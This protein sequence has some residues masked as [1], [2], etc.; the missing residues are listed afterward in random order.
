RNVD[1]VS[2]L[3][4]AGT[5]R[6]TLFANGD[7]SARTVLY[8]EPA[9]ELPAGERALMLLWGGRTAAPQRFRAPSL[10]RLDGPAQRAAVTAA[11]ERLRQEGSDPLLLYCTGHGSQSRDR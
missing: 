9:R 5:P 2:H 7:T 11:F 10:G 6:I 8:E 4:P 1:Y 3:L